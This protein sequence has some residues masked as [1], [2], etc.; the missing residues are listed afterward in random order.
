MRALLSF[1]ALLIIALIIGAI[2][3][4]PVYLFLA[5]WFEP[6]FEGVA[7]RI[8]LLTVL[9]LIFFAVKIFGIQSWQDI[10]Y[11]ANKKEFWKN[12]LVG[13]GLGILIMSPVI[14]GLL[15]TKNRVL[16][17][18]WDWSLT[19]F[20]PLALTALVSGLLISLIEETLIR[21]AMLTVIQRQSSIFFAIISTSFI[22][23]FIHFIEPEVKIDPNDITWDSGFILLQSAFSL[24]SSPTN[25]FDSFIALF[26]AG[27]LLAIIKVRTNKLSI[28]IG[29][30]TGWVF[31]IKIF[32]KITDPN[33]QSEYA[34]LT[35]SYDNVIGYLAAICIFI[36][37]TIFLRSKRSMV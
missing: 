9:I 19:R 2:I 31:I 37:I 6:E 4:Y 11:G 28:C 27:A 18:D 5:N 29:I 15:L 7:S 22:Y 21:G 12:L 26:L 25:I 14:A 33:M 17:V 13:I 10:G 3:S 1:I 16:V 34:Y 32:R 35:G 36:F 20:L 23:A 8:V 24:F 30:H